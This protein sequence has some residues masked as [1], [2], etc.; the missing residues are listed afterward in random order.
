MKKIVA[1]GLC[2]ALLAASIQQARSHLA[3]YICVS[4]GTAIIGG[5]AYFMVKG[6]RPKYYCM[7]DEDGNRFYSNATRTER[8]ANSWTVTGGPYDSAEEAAA[9]CVTTNPSLISMVDEINIPTVKFHIER[10]YDL[11]NWV[12]V[13]TLNDDPGHFSWTDTNAINSVSQS[14]YRATY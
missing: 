1:I 8:E 13:A 11:T 3:L 9:G 10:S 2:A 14:F 5:I 4:G 6:C 12:R 7:T